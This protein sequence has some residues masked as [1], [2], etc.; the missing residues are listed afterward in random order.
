MQ[1]T[2]VGAILEVLVVDLPPGRPPARGLEWTFL[3]NHAHVLL[4]LAGDPQCRLRDVA[5]RVGITER[6][7]QAIVADL[8]AEGYLTRIR[9]GRR[10]VYRLHPH[11]RFRHPAESGHRIGELIGLFVQRR[12]GEEAA[13]SA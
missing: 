11:K 10:N 4:A 12:T 3:T 2:G 13:G 1:R 5:A 8:E 7:V 9:V 6:S